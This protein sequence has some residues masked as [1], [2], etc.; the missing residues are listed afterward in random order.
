MQLSDVFLNLGEDRFSQLL[1]SISIGKLRTYQLFERLKF[2]LHLN[3]LNTETLRKAAPRLFERLGAHDEEFA[4]DLSQA[5]LVSHLDLIVAVLNFLGI[6]HE[7][8][9][10]VKD[11]DA[12]PY[13]TDGWE[14]RVYEKFK[15]EFPDALLLFYINHLG[16]E[17]GKAETPFLPAAA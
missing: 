1:R 12:V 6:P 10:F 8:G 13:L 3:K 16:L 2:R 11:L 9:F 5:V 15:G 14:A 4:T 17:L 7:E